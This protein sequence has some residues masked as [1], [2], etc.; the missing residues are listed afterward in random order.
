MSEYKPLEA[1]S[2]VIELKPDKKY[3]LVFIG[4]TFDQVEQAKARLK[5]SGIQGVGIGLPDG[6]HLQVVECSDEVLV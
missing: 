1:V 3:L 5:A 4:A 6:V 2:N